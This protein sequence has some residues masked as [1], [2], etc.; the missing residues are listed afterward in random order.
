[1]EDGRRTYDNAGRREQARRRRA[2][3][4]EACRAVLERD[5]Y[6]ELTIRAVAAAAGVSQETIYK[7]YGNKR[8]L[9]K[10]LYDVTLAGD[11]EP[12]ALGQRP[13]MRRLL[14]EP[15]P[16]RKIATY[17]HLARRVSERV[18]AIAAQLDAELT[19][20]TDRERLIGT[21]RFVGHLAE[22]GHLRPGLDAVQ[23]ADACWLLLSPQVYRLATSGRGWSADDYEAWLARMLTAALL[24]AGSAPSGGSSPAS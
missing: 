14:L 1:M 16:G 12:V 15:D 3:I 5:G 8:A 11:D 6:A 21:T 19:A 13:E 7:V 17:A 20:E 9:V 18:G 22:G 24:P 23:A 10:A 4:L 2:A